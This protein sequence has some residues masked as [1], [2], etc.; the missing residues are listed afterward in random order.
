MKI[1]RPNKIQIK[2]FKWIETYEEDTFAPTVL[3]L[4]GERP[5]APLGSDAFVIT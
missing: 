3:A 5:V 2:D 1:H 4:R